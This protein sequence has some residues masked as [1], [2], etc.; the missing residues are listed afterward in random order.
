M[1]DRRG[2]GHRTNGNVSRSLPYSGPQNIPNSRPSGI[3]MDSPDPG[4]FKLTRYVI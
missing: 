4:H 2:M 3:E 1:D